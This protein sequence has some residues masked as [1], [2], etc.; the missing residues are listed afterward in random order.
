[1]DF[2]VTV[3]SEAYRD[4]S[5]IVNFLAD[6]NPGAAHR[7]GNSLLDASLTLARLPYRGAPVRSR[8]NYRKL[9]HPPHYLV[10]YRIDEREHRVF[11]V[12]IWDARQNPSLLRIS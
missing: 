1:M 10:F 6:K 11:I 4:L 12:R 8:P 7:L 9:V 2:K 3:V 5:A